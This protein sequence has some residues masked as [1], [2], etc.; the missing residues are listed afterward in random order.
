MC[1]K[2]VAINAN[3]FDELNERQAT[4]SEFIAF[5]GGNPSTQGLAVQIAEYR[6]FMSTAVM[7]DILEALK[8]ND[9]TDAGI[10]ASIGSLIEEALDARTPAALLAVLQFQEYKAA[11]GL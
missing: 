3:K 8:A 1:G 6:K 9:I 4:A 11:H 7:E 2:S 10:V 5:N